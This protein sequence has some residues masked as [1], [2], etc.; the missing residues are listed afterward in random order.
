LI[1]PI[2]SIIIPCYNQG[3]FLSDCLLSI[4]NDLFTE[5]EVIVVNDGSAD[6]TKS[7]AEKFEVRDSR[8]KVISQVNQGLSSAR[9]VGMRLATGQY[10]LFLDADDWIEK[11]FLSRLD[12]EIK[13]NSGFEL[14]GFGYGYW[15]KPGGNCY[16]VHNSGIDGVIYP[17]VLTTNIGPCHAQ[18]IDREFAKSIGEFDTTLRSCEDW[19]FWMRA[20]KMGAKL[21][22]LPILGVGY[23]YVPTSMS[24]NP[25]IMY[26][27]LSEVSKRA[28]KVDQRLSLNG[29]FNVATE[30]D[31]SDE[32]KKHFFQNL[33]VMIH[34]NRVAE[35]V[36]WFENEKEINSWVISDVDFNRMSSYLSWRYFNRLDLIEMLET[37]LI[38]SLNEF[39]KII[40]I[41][42]PKA[43]KLIIHLL[44]PQFMIKNHLKYGR[45]LGGA[46]NRLTL[47]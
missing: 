10:L 11:G 42:K 24:R 25:K 31:L 21:H 38:P 47:H 16:H 34:K 15:D 8:I 19:D 9:N 27:S 7:I 6:N 29:K 33:G 2:F 46:L 18:V 35:A 13:C 28:A 44:K 14:Y 17:K 43:K 41:E 1:Q 20:G 22:Y 45:V 3:E 40:G 4:L 36:E 30:L 23:R 12:R 32:K 26:V 5:L 39:F 37:S